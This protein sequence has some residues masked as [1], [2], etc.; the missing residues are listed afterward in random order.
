MGQKGNSGQMIRGNGNRLLKGASGLAIAG[1]LVK[2]LS[3]VY[4]I[5]FQNKLGDA[6]FYVF[7]QAYP[8]YAFAQLLSASSLPQFLAGRLV[9]SQG[10]KDEGDIL[11]Q[12]F[13][14]IGSLSF[15]MALALFFFAGEIA[16]WM[17]DKAL[18][19]VIKQVSWAYCL[20]APLSLMRG[21]LQAK[22]QWT[23]LAYSLIVEQAVRVGVILYACYGFLSNSLYQVSSVAML[24]GFF[25]GL[26]AIFLLMM[27]GL[28]LPLWSKNKKRSSIKGENRIA[29]WLK[30]AKIFLEQASV[31]IAFAALLIA[32]QAVDSFSIFK[33]L[34]ALE[35]KAS[36]AK[37]LKGVYD[38]G[39]PIIQLGAVFVTSL[40]TTYMPTLRKSFS[41]DK[42]IFRKKA[43]ELLR[44]N[45]L[46][47]LYLTMGLIAVMKALNTT[48]FEDSAGSLALQVFALGLLPLSFILSQQ[49]IYQGQSRF[50]HSLLALLLGLTVKAFLTYPLTRYLGIVGASL[51]TTL[52]LAVIALELQRKSDVGFVF[53]M[54][55]SL[56][57]L[58]EVGLMGAICLAVFYGI[59]PENRWGH[60]L[61]LGLQVGIGLGLG[62]FF[63]LKANYLTKE[64]WEILP[65]GEKILGLKKHFFAK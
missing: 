65:L 26:A 55:D 28:K 19:S 6:G 57:Q 62:I 48:L 63:I 8:F 17:G 10:E 15:L 58:L 44:I 31:F 32:F 51:A 50:R 13:I 59:S 42:E 45:Q 21:Q 7:Q 37:S 39:Q 4:R 20:I 12:S 33:A 27:S 61:T 11:R 18:S 14:F 56:R 9:E 34:K 52:A 16:S 22:G 64:E 38:R 23:L 30:E 54:R 60:L 46:S 41:E 36:L 29:F 2:F 40:A 5:P 1:F 25:G 43:K 49:A 24:G 53:T 3:A 47:S 35:G